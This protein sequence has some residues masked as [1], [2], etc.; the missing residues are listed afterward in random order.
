MTASALNSAHASNFA[1]AWYRAWNSH[2][3]EEIL[4]H[5][6]DD[7]TLVSP[8]AAALLGDPTGEVRG[9][10]ALRAYFQKGLAAYPNLRF[11]PIDVMF[12]VR[13]VV[14]CY[15]NQKGTKTAEFMELDARGKVTRVVANYSG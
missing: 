11:E 12:G 10:A 8:T 7:V 15:V 13:S 1:D 3:L 4:S 5:Y 6:T 14:L 2:D 9:K